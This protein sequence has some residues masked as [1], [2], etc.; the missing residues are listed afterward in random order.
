MY[1]G[2]LF[3]EEIRGPFAKAGC[4]L[5]VRVPDR[6]QMSVRVRSVAWE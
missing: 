6:A 3:G 2:C 4:L 5:Q 1:E